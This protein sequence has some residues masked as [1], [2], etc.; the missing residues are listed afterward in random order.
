MLV[1]PSALAF[2]P[3]TPRASTKRELA[4]PRKNSNAESVE[5]LANDAPKHKSLVGPKPEGPWYTRAYMWWFVKWLVLRGVDQ[6]I[7]GSQSEKVGHRR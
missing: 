3:R 1:A 5:P 4:A 7:V 6:D 2:L